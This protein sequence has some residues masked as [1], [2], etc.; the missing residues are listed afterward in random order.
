MVTTSLISIENSYRARSEEVR[1]LN[2]FTDKLAKEN[3]NLRVQLSIQ[4][5]LFELQ[6][7]SRVILYGDIYP[8]AHYDIVVGQK[9]YMITCTKEEIITGSFSCSFEKYPAPPISKKTRP[10][11][12]I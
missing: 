7:S 1:F 12:E 4:E 8:N 3:F 9:D 10:D 5:L 11:A 6:S 2:S